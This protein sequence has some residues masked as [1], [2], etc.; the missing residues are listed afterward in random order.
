MTLANDSYANSEDAR[1]HDRAD[2]SALLQHP[3]RND[4][5]L[6]DGSELIRNVTLRMFT[7]DNFA[8]TGPAPSGPEEPVL[9]GS[10]GK[11]EAQRFVRLHRAR[12]RNKITR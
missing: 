9:Y 7:S 5:F 10:C 12:R 8:P 6:A 1:P 11:A 4:L 2:R 3:K